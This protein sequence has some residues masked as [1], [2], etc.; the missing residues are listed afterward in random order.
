MDS[1][2]QIEKG[3]SKRNLISRLTNV[4]LGQQKLLHHSRPQQIIINQPP[5]HVFKRF[6]HQS[7]VK[8]PD[9]AKGIHQDCLGTSLPKYL[10][11]AILRI[12]IFPGCIHFLGVLRGA[13]HAV[14]PAQIQQHNAMASLPDWQ[15]GGGASNDNLGTLQLGTRDE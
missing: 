5:D 13:N 4:S 14:Q 11:R 15:V 1:P 2:G 12:H 8:K 9:L 7:E 3:L 6:L 10:L